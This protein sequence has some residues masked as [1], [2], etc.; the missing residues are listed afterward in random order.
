MYMNSGQFVRNKKH[1]A[2]GNANAMHALLL[3]IAVISKLAIGTA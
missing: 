3:A 1:C 2:Q